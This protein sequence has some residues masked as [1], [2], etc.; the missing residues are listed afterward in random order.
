M[1]RPTVVQTYNEMLT[2]KENEQ[3]SDTCYNIILV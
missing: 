2:V 3:N 1:D